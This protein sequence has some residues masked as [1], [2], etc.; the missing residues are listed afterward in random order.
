MAIEFG[1]ERCTA[2]TEDCLWIYTKV[3]SD[4]YCLVGKFSGTKDWP[5]KLM[6]VPGHSLWF[7]MQ[8][9]ALYENAGQEQMYGFR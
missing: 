4:T 1:E 5:D 2:Q 6:L 9:S 8:T 7:V 3:D